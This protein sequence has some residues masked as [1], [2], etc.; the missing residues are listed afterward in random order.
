MSRIFLGPNNDYIIYDNF[1]VP[2]RVY[3]VI[4]GY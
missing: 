3:E 1:G 4:R 2:K